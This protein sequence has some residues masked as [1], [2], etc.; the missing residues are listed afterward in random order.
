MILQD[1]FFQLSKSV[2][3]LIL[4]ND[5]SKQRC[6][7][8]QVQSRKIFGFIVPSMKKKSVVHKWMTEHSSNGYLKDI[9][10]LL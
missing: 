9:L 3:F 2:P 10:F 6:T 7:K 1:N 5:S 8:I 4:S